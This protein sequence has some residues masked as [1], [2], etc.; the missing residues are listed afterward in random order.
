[1]STI[2]TIV[3]S[4]WSLILSEPVYTQALVVAGIALGTSFGLGWTG[5]QVGAVSAFSAALLS[6]LTRKA[7]T[8]LENPV[9]PVG[10]AYTVTTPAGQ[11]DYKAT[12]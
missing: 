3:R 6:L 2:R 8:P 9:L 12:A 1:M 10:T 7:V 11:A 4:I 5:G